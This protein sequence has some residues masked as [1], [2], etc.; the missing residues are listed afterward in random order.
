MK[1]QAM[2]SESHQMS[3]ARFRLVSETYPEEE[4][5][6]VDRVGGLVERLGGYVRGFSAALDLMDWSLIH[7]HELP[8]MTGQAWRII[9]AKEASMM[10]YNVGVAHSLLRGSFKECPTLRAR[11][12][13]TRLREGTKMIEM[14]LP[15]IHSVRHA[16]SHSA[17]LAADPERNALRRET[18]IFPGAVAV[19]GTRFSS[20]LINRSYTDTINGE[21]AQCDITT[22]TLDGLIAV[23]EL[24]FSAFEN[25]R[26][27]PLPPRPPVSQTG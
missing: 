12:D 22:E 3:F 24:T 8:R 18:E 14:L 1:E 20:C 27:G 9:A 5:L 11:V 19:K 25:A 13:H 17:E 10:A 2:L 6:A 23:G 15:D 7:D 4:G 16:I 21:L 26:S